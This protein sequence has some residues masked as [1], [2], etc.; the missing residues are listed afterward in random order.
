[1][2]KIWKKIKKL[3]S[4]F[5]KLTKTYNPAMLAA[6]VVFYLLMVL[7]PLSALFFHVLS[8]LQLETVF[9]DLL[10][11]PARLPIDFISGS[12]LIIN[13]LWVSSRLLDALNI[14]SDTVYYTVKARS[15]WWR[16]LY[17]FILMIVFILIVIIVVII[18]IGISYLS[19]LFVRSALFQKTPLLLSVIQIGQLI[20]QFL[21]ILALTTF[22]YKYTI[23]VKIKLKTVIKTC[24]LVLVAWFVLTYIF[25]SFIITYQHESYSLL[26]GTLANT[27]LFLFWLYLMSY[28]FIYGLIYN[29]YLYQKKYKG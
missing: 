25:Q 22:I 19:G 21:A 24:S 3:N 12:I 17:S 7:L 15:S 27:F 1:M 5:S 23:P 6:A 26:Y 14:A 8:L 29:Y 16:R 4:T 20:V 11:A 9:D 28:V 2:K 13:L 18:L 10:S